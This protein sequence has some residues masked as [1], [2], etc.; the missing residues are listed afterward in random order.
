MRQRSITGRTNGLF[1][2]VLLATTAL[3]GIPAAFAQ[4]SG[5]G[6]ETVIVTAQKREENLQKVP[7]NV[8]VLS[9]QKLEELHL[10]DFTDFALYMPSVNYAVSGQGSNGGPGFSNVTMRGIA[11]DQNG[12][13]SGPLP[14][15][16]V[17]FD[18]Q[19]ITT[20]NGALDIPT[21]DIERVEA[22]SGPQGTLYGASSEAGTIR[23]ISNK[24]D[25]SEFSAAYSVEGN[26]VSNGG[27][28]YI[29]N[30]YINEPITDHMAVRLVAWDEHDAGYIDNIHGTRTY[31]FDVDKGGNGAPPIT[32]DNAGRAKNDYNTVD[33]FGARV[34]LGIDLDD[35]WTI[36][37]SLMAEK[38]DSDGVFGFNKNGNYGYNRPLG[39]LQV[40]HFFPEFVHD[41]WYQAALTIQGKIGN[42]DAIYSGGY[43]NRRIESGADYTD[44]TF[45]YNQIY[46]SY[47]E[48]YDNAGNQ[49]NPSQFL[50]GKDH[51][52]KQSHEFRVSS[53]KDDRFRFLLGAFYERQTHDIFQDYIIKNLNT[54]SAEDCP[55]FCSVTGF[56]GTFW[57]TDET[58]VDRDYAV[59]GEISY[60]ILPNLT[61]TAGLR[62]FHA[63]NSLQG[64]FGFQ[65]FESRCDPQFGFSNHG[66]CADLDADVVESGETHRVNLTWQI[67]PDRMVYFTYS[68]GFRPGGVNRRTDIPG[69]GPYN[70][71]SLDN[72]EVGWKTSWD[73]NRL[74]LNGDLFWENWNQ[75][76]FPFLDPNSVTII[77][78]IGQATSKGAEAEVSWLPIDNLTLS[79]SAAYTEATL[80]TDYCGEPCSDPGAV[81]K[82]RAGTQMPITPKWKLNGTAR[83]QWNIGDFL[84]HVQG[85]IVHESGRWADLRAAERSLL[86]QVKAFTTFDFTAGVDRDNWSLELALL[87]VTDERAE[88]GRYAECTP[89][90]CGPQTYILPARP[91]TIAL[92]FSQKF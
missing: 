54:V 36:T 50:Y 37:P 5:E 62:G 72:Y 59:F 12:N 13:H 70:S 28:G 22:L 57:L 73:D 77:Q 24:P 18:E 31:T 63:D 3:S 34:A 91:R 56:P 43:M 14:T 65:S 75:F 26:K 90:T 87:N 89:G 66:H 92:T 39:D 78:N 79:G 41:E 2:P 61:L 69:V 64:W 71:D 42:L 7:M 60:D 25:P 9:T 19:P 67:D 40:I 51:F 47:T 48:L 68:T 23:I 29:L 49:I 88:L 55:G 81:V 46:V 86:G 32:I 84:A 74:R 30:G 58:R 4:T 45:F 33:K 6:L 76:Q 1:L 11:S 80:S 21:Y 20:I 52:T 35:N 38:E 10:T 16:G 44:Y 82:A 83:Y 8:Q 53:S 27:F 85:S 15:V 17:Y